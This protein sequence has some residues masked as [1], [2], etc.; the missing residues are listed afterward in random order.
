[1][2]HL[3]GFRTL[4]CAGRRANL[5]LC[6]AQSISKAKGLWRGSNRE[7]C[8]PKKKDGKCRPFSLCAPRTYGSQCVSVRRRKAGGDFAM[9]NPKTHFAEAPRTK[10]KT[11]SMD[12]VFSF[13]APSGIQDPALRRTTYKFE[14][15][16]SAK[17]IQSPKA[18][19]GFESGT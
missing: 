9:R 18:L 6:A 11:P 1:M 14:A 3:Q 13:G 15:M 2:V 7:L 16:C 4:L 5:K 10:E 8:K 19:E 17:L 12:G